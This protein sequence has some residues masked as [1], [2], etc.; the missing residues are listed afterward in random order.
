[1]PTSSSEPSEQPV[2]RLERWEC[3]RA[4]GQVL[5]C[6]HAENGETRV[7]ALSREQA[8]DLGVDLH[9]ASISEPQD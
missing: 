8:E 6:I 4:W 7:F 9:T 2:S 5:L 3:V 1:M